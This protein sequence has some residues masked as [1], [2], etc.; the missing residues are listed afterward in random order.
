MRKASAL[1]VKSKEEK[2]RCNAP[3]ANKSIKKEGDK[4]GI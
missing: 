1:I 2:V 4:W 3:I